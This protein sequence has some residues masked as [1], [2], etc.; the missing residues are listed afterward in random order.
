MYNNGYAG[1][2]GGLFGDLLVAAM[3]RTA[4]LSS[5]QLQREALAREAQSQEDMK[6]LM[7]AYEEMLKGSKR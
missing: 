5:E 3:A 2:T 6:Q 7:R 4:A 1:N